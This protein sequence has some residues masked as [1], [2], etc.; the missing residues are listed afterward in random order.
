MLPAA[1]AR[2]CVAKT[3]AAW[4]V[5]LLQA[6]SFRLSHEKVFTPLV[7]LAILIQNNPQLASVRKSF[8]KVAARLM[9]SV[10]LRAS[11][12]LSSRASLSNGVRV[13]TRRWQHMR[14]AWLEMVQMPQKGQVL[15][16]MHSTMYSACASSSMVTEQQ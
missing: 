13:V 5:V 8:P 2:A 16:M 11:L 15:V 6:A 14:T 3:L 4:R 10:S 12:L 9:E 7:T 1:D